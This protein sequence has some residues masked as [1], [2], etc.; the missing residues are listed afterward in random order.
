MIFFL[1][2]NPYFTFLKKIVGIIFIASLL[3]F[4]TISIY[5]PPLPNQSEI[6]TEI[7]SGEPIQSELSADQ[8]GESIVVNIENYEYR[9]TPL[10]NYEL[11]GLIVTDYNSDN[12]L[13]I[14][15]KDDPG[16]IKDICVVW[17]ENITN[18]S[19][20]E[21]KFT[22]GEFTCFYRWERKLENM[23]KGSFL[24]NNHLIPQSEIVS[25]AIKKSK[26]GD[27]VRVKGILADYSVYVDGKEIFKRKSSTV[28]N[29]S[30]NG[31]CE[32]IYVTDFEILQK[33][34][35]NFKVYQK[36]FGLTALY[37]G[38]LGF[39]LFLLG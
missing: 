8:K 16:N 22:S 13:D 31:A 24:S 25:S 38:I 33:N 7:K 26:L 39:I 3:I 9:L 30:G 29:D 15:H 10:Y 12:W 1:I 36:S 14:R 35:F 20:K 17:G 34:Q 18:G 37:S 11:K 2:G 28:R 21:V 32:I 27:Q 19:Y 5:K 23:V 6:L 4:L